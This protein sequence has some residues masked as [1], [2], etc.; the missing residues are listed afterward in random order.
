MPE[1]FRS[2]VRN[3]WF[4]WIRVFSSQGMARVQFPVA[5]SPQMTLVG[6]VFTVTVAVVAPMKPVTG[7]EAFATDRAPDLPLCEN[8]NDTV[9]ILLTLKTN[10]H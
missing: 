2:K 5:R 1:S 4:L 7:P 9:R 10:T 3:S 8:I 6:Q